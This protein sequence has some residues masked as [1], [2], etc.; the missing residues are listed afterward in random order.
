MAKTSNTVPISVCMPVY[1]GA[2][3]IRAA[4]RSVLSQTV[5]PQEIVISDSG[6]SDGSDDILREETRRTQANV[7]ILPTKTPGMV[8]NWNSTIRG[9]SGKYIK[10]LFQDDLLH[11]TCLEEML[12]VAECD[13]RIGFVFSPREL[14]VE[15]SAQ[16]AAAEW[17]LRYHDLSAAFGKLET[18]QPGS[19]LLKSPKLLQEPLN[20]IGEPTAVLVRTALFREIGLFNEKMRQLVDMEMWVRLMAIS[21]VGY[22]PRALASLRVHSGRASARHASEEISRFEHERLFDTLRSPI[23]YPLLHRRVR[24]ALGGAQGGPHGLV[25]SRVKPLLRRLKDLVWAIAPNSCRL[26]LHHFRHY[27]DYIWIPKQLLQYAEDSLFTFNAAPFLN[28]DKFLCAYHAGAQTDSWHGVSIRWRAYVAC[29]AA[30]YASRLDGDFV[31]CGVNRGGLARAIVDY[32]GFE[33]LNRHFYLIDTFSG[34]VPAYLSEEE[35]KKGIL[36]AY[37]YYS[38]NSAEIV[39]KTFARFRNVKVVQGVVPDILSSLPIT[40]LAFLSL[41]MNC[42]MPEITAAEYFWDRMCPGGVILLDDYGNPL[43]SEQQK[44]FDDFAR[45]RGVEVLALPTGQGLI[46]KTA[47]T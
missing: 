44:A 36:S 19:S 26:R 9:A 6:S 18:T 22:I 43:H 5:V 4:I 13:E 31:E 10:F 41:D 23:I 14:L 29:W 25:A 11:P 33:R 30:S 15:S 16:A 35:I 32:I 40:R 7:I 27:Q 21:H 24:R 38:D 8:A 39:G 45:H 47:D 34:L 12:E 20:K 3:Y 1:N 2:L 37:S 28:D 42:T 46:F 17:L